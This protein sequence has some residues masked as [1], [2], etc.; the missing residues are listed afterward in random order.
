[1]SPYSLVKLHQ[2]SLG[3]KVGKK[4]AISQRT[5]WPVPYLPNPLSYRALSLSREGIV[6]LSFIYSTILAYEACVRW[7]TGTMGWS[8]GLQCHCTRA[9]CLCFC[10]CAAS[11][12]D[13]AKP[14]DRIRKEKC[15]FASCWCTIATERRVGSQPVGLILSV[16]AARLKEA[17]G[18]WMVC[19]I[20]A[21][22]C[23]WVALADFFRQAEIWV[24]DALRVEMGIQKIL[25]WTL[26]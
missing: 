25:S 18:K 20:C 14:P 7:G 1:M 9:C 10:V 16:P 8:V 12:P 24:T 13:S 2:S 5:G 4:I 19:T 22:P 3:G 26:V 17:N 21:L 23:H 15:N 11:N 6:C